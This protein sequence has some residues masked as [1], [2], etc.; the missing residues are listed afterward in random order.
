MAGAVR[1]M[2]GVEDLASKE[3]DKVVPLHQGSTARDFLTF[4]ML[5]ANYEKIP[6]TSVTLKRIDNEVGAGRA[7]SLR[8]LTG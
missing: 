4:S 2:F 8:A 1:V 7:P 3:A 6:G 5:K